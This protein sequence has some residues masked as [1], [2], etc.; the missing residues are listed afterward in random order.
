[1]IYWYCTVNISIGLLFLNFSCGCPL[2]TG[3]LKLDA[4]LQSVS[5]MHLDRDGHQLCTSGSE[6]DYHHRVRP[7]YKQ[8]EMRIQPLCSWQCFH[9]HSN[10]LASWIGNCFLL[11]FPSTYW[12]LRTG[13]AR[14]EAEEPLS[15]NILWIPLRNIMAMHPVVARI[16]DGRVFNIAWT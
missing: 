1:M 4:V 5:T 13:T 9:I 6:I 16:C 7:I 10:V 3:I 12:L 11:I 2:T 14:L 15:L 8:R